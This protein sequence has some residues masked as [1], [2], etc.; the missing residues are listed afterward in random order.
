MSWNRINFATRMA[1]GLSLMALA[2][3]ALAIPGCSKKTGSDDSG[4]VVATVGER[5]IKLREV[6][7]P[8]IASSVNYDTP[9]A[10]LAA[11]RKQLDKLIQEKFLVIGAYAHALDADIGIVELID[12]EK[13][14]FLLDELYR[15]Q[16]LAKVSVPE[17]DVKAWFE[18]FFDRVRP[19]HIVVESKALAD[20]IMDQLKKGADFGD[21]AEKYSI[22]KSR[23]TLA[24]T[25]S[26]ASPAAKCSAFRTIRSRRRSK[27]A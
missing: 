13:D 8:I 12:R 1:A 14:K 16:V 7:D 27:T 11:R 3:I 17:S 23:A 10:E 9:E 25:S 24:G 26:S 20:S 2:V 5:A 21:L 4:P 15:T 18:H 22:D 19:K 6:T